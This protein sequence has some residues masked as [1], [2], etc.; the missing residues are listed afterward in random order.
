MSHLV[1]GSTTDLI[2]GAVLTGADVGDSLAADALIQGDE[3]TVYADKAYDSQARREALTEAG[4]IA[5]VMYRRHPCQRV[6]FM[7]GSQLG[8]TESGGNWIGY[9]LV[10]PVGLH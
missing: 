1:C 8:A 10:N 5:A 2:R 3:V 4:I 6:V 9:L 7:K